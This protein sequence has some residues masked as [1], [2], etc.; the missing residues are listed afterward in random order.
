MLECNYPVGISLI[1]VHVPN[2]RVSKSSLGR[3]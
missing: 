2:K 1:A 3:S